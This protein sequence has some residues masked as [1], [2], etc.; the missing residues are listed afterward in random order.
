L[1]GSFQ[2]GWTEEKYK[3]KPGD[4]LYGISQSFGI[5]IEAL[6]KANAL[7]RDAIKPNQIL[8]IPSQREKKRDEAARRPSHSPLTQLTAKNVQPL[9]GK[10]GSYVIQKGDTLSCISRK[11]G[12]PIEEIK[13]MNHLGTSSLKIGQVLHLPRDRNRGDEESEELGDG[14]EMIEALQPEGDPVAYTPLEKWSNPEERN[15]FIRVVKNFLGVP[16]KLGGSTLKGIDCSAFVKK[17]YEIFNTQLPRT[18]REQFSIG[19]KVEKGQL[20]EGDLVFFRRRGNSAHVGIYIGDN[21]FVHASSSNREVKIDDLDTPYYNKR[22]LKGVRVKE[23]E[24]EI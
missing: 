20:E 17:I 7:R 21:Q 19:K 23:L 11:V 3:V 4:T 15:L 16:Y 22:F 1:L 8:V 12:I 18:T 13:K 10:S 14:E 2:K 5:H 24:K 6:K 9:L